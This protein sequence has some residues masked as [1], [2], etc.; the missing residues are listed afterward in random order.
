MSTPSVMPVECEADI[1]HVRQQGRAM[2]KEIGFSATECTLIATAISEVARN[3]IEYAIKGKI[4][5]LRL[6]DFGRVGIRIIAVDQGPGIPDP[7]LAMTDGF[8][9]GGSL[10]MG[11]P[12]ARRLMDDLELSATQGGG[13]TVTLTRWV[14]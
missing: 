14:E 11:L 12:G 4:Q 7:S 9:T 1:V 13:T 5:L 6:Q 8:S 10:G 3:I 2:A